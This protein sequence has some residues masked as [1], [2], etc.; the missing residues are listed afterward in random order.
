MAKRG[1][2]HIPG[3]GSNMCQGHVLRGENGECEEGPKCMKHREKG[4]WLREEARK[5]EW[6]ETR[7]D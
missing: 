2:E 5:W 7:L 6:V 4:V 3:R 1:G